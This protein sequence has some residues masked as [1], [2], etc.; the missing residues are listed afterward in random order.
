MSAIA[1]KLAGGGHVLRTGGS[2]GADQAFHAG[3]TAGGGDVELYLPWATFEARALAQLGAVTFRM[4]RPEPHAYSAAAGHHPRWAS[5]PAAART[6]LARD[7]HQV[8]GA[9]VLEPDRSAFVICWT[10]DGS[11]DGAGS[12]SGGTGQALRVAARHGITVFNLAREDHHARLAAFAGV[13][14]APVAAMAL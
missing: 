14:V 9:D 10:P 5:L 1:H 7:V 4:P 11:V 12:A 2:P 6:L 13:A 8:L 3:A